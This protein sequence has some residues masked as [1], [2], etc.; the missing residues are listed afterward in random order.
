M[1]VLT[2]PTSP[3][4]GENY[5]GPNNVLYTYDGVKWVV[6]TTTITSTTVTNL[7]EDKSGELLSNG[8]HNGI[9]VNYNNSTNELTLSIDVDGGTASSTY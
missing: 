8:P 4:S 5:T 2:F 6:T 9:T 7:V 1:T 3:V